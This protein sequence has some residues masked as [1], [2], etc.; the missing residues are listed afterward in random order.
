MLNACGVEVP[1]LTSALSRQLDHPNIVK[2]LGACVTPPKLCFIME[3]CQDSLYNRLH[4]KRETF[5]DVELINFAVSPSFPFPGHLVASLRQNFCGVSQ[6]F[7]SHNCFLS[8]CMC[9]IAERCGRWNELLAHSHTLHY[10]SGL[11]EP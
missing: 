3:L 7:Y 11:K 1:V 5:T 8:V 4:V 2:F 10:S 9:S 6:T